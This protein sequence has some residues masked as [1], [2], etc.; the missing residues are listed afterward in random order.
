[1]EVVILPIYRPF[2]GSGPLR[3]QLATVPVVSAIILSHFKTMQRIDRQVGSSYNI[4]Q[5]TATI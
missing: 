5:S 3:W 4:F 2:L 1:M